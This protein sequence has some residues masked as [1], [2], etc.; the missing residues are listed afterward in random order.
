MSNHQKV[1]RANETS[2]TPRQ[3]AAISDLGVMIE[4]VELTSE[5]V[6][7]IDAAQQRQYR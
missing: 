7:A 2:P 5:G 3:A 4:V 6:A 1:L